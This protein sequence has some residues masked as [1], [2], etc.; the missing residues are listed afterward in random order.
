[1]SAAANTNRRDRRA[2][3][4]ANRSFPVELVRVPPEDWTG[5]FRPTGISE[6]WRSR[7][8]LVQVYTHEAAERITVS[9]TEV[10]GERWRED[11]SWDDLQRLK[12]ECGRGDRC[13]VEIF[14]PDSEVVNVASMRHLWLCDPPPFMWTREGHS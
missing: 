11:I 7:E 13:A 3:A 6:V 8:F 5:T 14:P 10:V 12:R 9:R 4:A 1:M 2:L